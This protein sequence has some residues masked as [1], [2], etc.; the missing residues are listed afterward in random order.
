MEDFIISKDNHKLYKS[1][2]ITCGADRGYKR[3]YLSKKNCRSCS[4]KFR[5]EKLG[6]PM[7]GKKHSNKEKFRKNTYSNVDYDDAIIEYTKTGNKIIKYRQSCPKC[8]KD[9]G[10]RKQIDARRTCVG[11]QHDIR[12]KYTPEQRRLRNAVKANISARLRSRNSGKNYTST[13][14]MLDFTFEE[15]CKNLEDKFKDGMTM[16]NYGEWE[17]DHIKPDSLFNYESYN[18]IGFKKS[19]SLDNLQPLWKSENASKSN[20]WEEK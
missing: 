13:F 14:S 11:C 16:E 8:E 10:Y 1:E 9:I 7:Q 15:L 12:R 2:C 3:K 5:Y 18:D 20:K 6:N 19:W 4:A 17:I